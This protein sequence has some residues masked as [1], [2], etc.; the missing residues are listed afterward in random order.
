M[1]G[2]ISDIGHWA[3]VNN[4]ELNFDHVFFYLTDPECGIEKV[5]EFGYRQKFARYQ[6]GILIGG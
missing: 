2:R 4:P 5:A 1:E 3:A 6:A